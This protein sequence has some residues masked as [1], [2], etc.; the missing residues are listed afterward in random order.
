MGPRSASYNES[1]YIGYRYY[2][3]AGASVAFRSGTAFPTQPSPIPACTCRPKKLA[4]HEALEVSFRVR[5]TGARAGRANESTFRT[6]T[7]AR[8][9]R[10]AP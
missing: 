7:P 8:T 2:D 5:N 9:S 10:C 3:K 6:W 1:I 4:R